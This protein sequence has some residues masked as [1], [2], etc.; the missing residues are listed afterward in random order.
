MKRRYSS[1]LSFIDML[2]NIL[3]GFVF[4]FIIAFL[5]INPV[6]KKNDIPSKAEIMIIL[7]WDD[8]SVDD[9]DI[10][11]KPQDSSN[12]PISFKVK[13]VGFWHLDRDDLG[14][15]NDTIKV[16][17]Q[18]RI[19]SINREVVTMRGIQTGD[20]FI[21]VHIYSKRDSKPTPFTVT[22][23]DINPYREVIVYKGMS[24]QQNQIFVLPGFTID[25]DGNITNVFEDDTIFAAKRQ[26]HD[27]VIYSF[28][29]TGRREHTP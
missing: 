7:Q 17:G 22:V 24:E 14:T 29:G 18:T 3:I 16:D 15:A 12:L 6:T 26:P 11:L 13:N 5:M 20:V 28:G 19:L 4:L 9:I 10:W 8:L 21:N 27:N 23:M 1:N 25:S 2:F